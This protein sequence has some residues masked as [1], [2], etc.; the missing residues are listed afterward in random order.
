MSGPTDILPPSC[1]VQLRTSCTSTGKAQFRS[2][3]LTAGEPLD[4][5]SEVYCDYSC[6]PVD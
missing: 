1:S 2:L 3:D 4:H 5:T 6:V